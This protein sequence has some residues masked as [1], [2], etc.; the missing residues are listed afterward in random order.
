MERALVTILNTAAQDPRAAIRNIVCTM[1]EPGPLADQLHRSVTIDSLRIKGRNRLAALKLSKL[2]ARLRPNIVHA[3]NFNTWADCLLACRLSPA[4]RPMPVLGF[5]GLETAGGFSVRRKRLARWIRSASKH[6]TTVSQSGARQLRD[7]LGVPRQH[8][9]ILPNGVDTTR[10][11]PAD[12]PTRD[13]IRIS[14]GIPDGRCVIVMVGSLVPVKDHQTA[15]EAVKRSAKDI[16]PTELLIVGD[17]P[18]LDT[19]RSG[20]QALP[21]NVR[22]SFLG[23]RGDVADVLRAAD[24]FL[25]TSRYEQMS[26][27]LLEAMACGVAAVATDVGDNPLL[28]EHQRSGLIVPAADPEALAQAVTDLLTSQDVRKRFSDNARRRAV[29]RFDIATAT[30]RYTRYYQTLINQGPA[31]DDELIR[32][33]SPSAGSGP[34]DDQEL[35]DVRDCGRRL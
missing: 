35:T 20:A 11:A 10:F 18:L 21:D 8:I 9:S 28:I 6:F 14:L 12:G 23:R 7:E 2:I 16:G 3:R 19:L 29:Q 33:P 15:I 27:A 5:H 17:G 22:A 25:L 30:E 32:A 26:N 31:N 1:R 34:E 13:A 24:L 4:P